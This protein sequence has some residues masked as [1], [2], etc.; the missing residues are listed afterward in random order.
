MFKNEVIDRYNALY[1]EEIQNIAHVYIYS[2][3]DVYIGHCVDLP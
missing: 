2:L 1:Y 3:A